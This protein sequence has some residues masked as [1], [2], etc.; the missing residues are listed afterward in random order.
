VVL[1]PIRMSSP[2]LPRSRSWFGSPNRG[3]HGPPVAAG[4][5]APHH[6]RA[7]ATNQDGHG[8]G[9]LAAQAAWMHGLKGTGEQPGERR[10]DQEADDRT[11]EMP[12]MA[13]WIPK[14]TSDARKNRSSAARLCCRQKILPQHNCLPTYV[15]DWGSPRPC[16]SFHAR[17]GARGKRGSD[18][19]KKGK[20]S[21]AV[22]PGHYGLVGT[23]RPLFQ[24]HGPGAAA[25]ASPAAPRCLQW[26][27]ARLA[28]RGPRRG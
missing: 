2:A 22:R 19:M 5:A 1:P 13:I 27:A 20:Q 24:K 21:L 25:T 23:I 26:P 7:A 12:G 18:E 14:R 17:S 16:V 4:R 8:R 11:R 3:R 10:L 28:G 15:K 6:V 9:T